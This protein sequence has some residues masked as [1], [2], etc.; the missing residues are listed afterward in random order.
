MTETISLVELNF[1]I[2]SGCCPKSITPALP[3]D[4]GHESWGL[5]LVAATRLCNLIVTTVAVPAKSCLLF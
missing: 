4:V 2:A 5:A 1:Q 3:S